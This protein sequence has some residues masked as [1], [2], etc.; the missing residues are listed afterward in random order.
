MGQYF[1]YNP[2]L[3]SNIKEIKYDFLGNKLVFNTNNGVFS[4]DRVD[5]G[6]NVLLNNLPDFKGTKHILDM[7]CGYGIIGIGLAKGYKET[8]VDMVDVNKSAVDLVKE[9]AKINHVNNINVY[10][11]SLY[12][13]Y[14]NEGINYLY[15][16]IISN[17]PIRAGKEIV[18]GIAIN[19]YSKLV[20]NGSIF[21]VI[22][23]KQGAES[24]IKKLNEVYGNAEIITKQNGYYILKS[25]KENG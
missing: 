21:F 9:N 4:K 22:Q 2:N 25:T 14:E 17:P 24:L 18:H 6:T 11:S 19:G 7:G 3:K 10:L 23:K 20:K 13:Y 8:V 12:E 15:D 16:A 1:D 5:F